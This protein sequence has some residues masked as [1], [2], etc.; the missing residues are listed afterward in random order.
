MHDLE[1][2]K[3]MNDRAY[4]KWL[5]EQRFL[6]AQLFRELSEILSKMEF[7]SESGVPDTAASEENGQAA[8]TDTR[9]LGKHQSQEDKPDQES[10]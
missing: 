1:R 10:E 3:A 7:S 2:I 8:Q 5:R 4:E 9:E 6:W